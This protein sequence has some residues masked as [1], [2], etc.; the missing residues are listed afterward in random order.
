MLCRAM[1]SFEYPLAGSH[2]I[3]TS[4]LT[5]YV[6]ALGPVVAPSSSSVAPRPSSSPVHAAA[7][8]ANVALMTSMRMR[9]DLIAP[10]CGFLGRS[11]PCERSGRLHPY[12]YRRVGQI[13]QGHLVDLDH[14]HFFFG[15]TGRNGPVDGLAGRLG[16]RRLT[17]SRAEVED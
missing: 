17:P 7:T 8:T 13:R 5:E 2:P 11:T 9:S 1:T 15:R 14:V 3:I 12:T 16:H 4:E 10:P 6:N